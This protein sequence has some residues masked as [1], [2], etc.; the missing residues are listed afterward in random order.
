MLLF[1]IVLVIVALVS[2]L[3]VG[4]LAR[5]LVPGPDPMSLG[6]TWLVGFVGSVV[7]GFLTYLVFGHYRHG[8]V[9]SVVGAVVVVL[10]IRALRGNRGGAPHR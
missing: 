8:L 3:V 10:L 6:M 1:L 9:G 2:G 4:A 5:L 7:G